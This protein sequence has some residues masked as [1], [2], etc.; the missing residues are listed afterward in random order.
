MFFVKKFATPL[1][2]LLTSAKEISFPDH[3]AFISLTTVINLQGGHFNP[4]DHL[5]AFIGIT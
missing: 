5:I 3:N 2:V 1:A 4:L